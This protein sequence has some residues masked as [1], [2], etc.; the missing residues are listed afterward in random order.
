MDNLQD[1]V[2]YDSLLFE[3]LKKIGWHAEQISWWN[4]KIDWAQYE[5]VI[6]RSTWDY[7]NNYREFLETLQNI[8]KQ[9]RLE[10]PLSL[11]QWNID[12]SYLR[13]L[14][15][16]GI[17][18]VPTEFRSG[19]KKGDI[20]NYFDQFSTGEIII[21]PAISANADDT[22]RLD[23]ATAVHME[24][25][26]INV[27]KSRSHL[28]QPFMKNIKEGEYS[29][30]YFGG[31]YSHTILKKPKTNDFRVQEEHGGVLAS[32]TPP[33]ELKNQAQKVI[34]TLDGVPLYARTDFVRS[35]ENTFALMELELIEPSLYF[36]MDKKAAEK[37]VSAFQEYL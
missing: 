28:V 19:I 12:K 27:F 4:K 17:E 29:L 26:L 33:V 2:C 5:F 31:K 36:N 13:D 15:N 34:Y 7:Q 37:F 1:F 18:I 14:R 8:E 24:R 9:T 10:N 11:V 30:F 23:R 21:K 35:P 22:F 16:K 6:I 32:V 3:P 20:A 25:K